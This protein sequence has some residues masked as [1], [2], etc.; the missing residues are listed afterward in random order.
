M[1]TPE[2]VATTGG[3]TVFPTHTAET[4]RERSAR[5]VLGHPTGRDG[6]RWRRPLP[7]IRRFALA[8]QTEAS[9]GATDGSSG[10]LGSDLT[11]T[12]A[13]PTDVSGATDSTTG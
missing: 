11:G 10:W 13:A 7:D 12:A 5:E 3:G 9:V 1:P 4:R 2:V 8:L 6:R